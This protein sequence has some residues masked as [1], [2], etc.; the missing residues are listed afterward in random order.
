VEF[1][2]RGESKNEEQRA[3]DFR[4]GPYREVVIC[5]VQRTPEQQGEDGVFGQVPAFANDV[6]NYLNV[7]PR[8]F[9]KEPV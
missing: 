9:W 2:R 5:Q 7:C 6:V 8:H 3:A 4:P 1:I